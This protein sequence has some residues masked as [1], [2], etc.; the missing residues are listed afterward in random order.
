[1]SDPT[2]AVR[3]AVFAKLTGG[4]IGVP[5]YSVAPANQTPP[6][7]LIDSVALEPA[8]TKSSRAWPVT[9]EVVTVV[10]TTRP[11]DVEQYMSRILTA[12]QG[13][14]LSVSGLSVFPLRLTASVAEPEPE[15]TLFFGRQSF[16]TTAQI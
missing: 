4:E 2:N 9:V 5:I 14:P 15:R 7:V 11:A 13:Q 10:E 16:R 3:Q 8:N 6:Y 1:M 12:L